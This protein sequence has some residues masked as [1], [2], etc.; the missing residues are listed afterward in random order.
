MK[1]FA[2]TTAVQTGLMEELYGLLT[3]TARDMERLYDSL[4][5]QQRAIVEWDY[6]V[7][8]GSVGEQNRLNRR[9]RA[10]EK[11]RRELIDQLSDKPGISIRELAVSL[12]E[13]W[14]SRLNRAA[15]NIRETVGK[16]GA[17]KKQNEFL[18][19]KAR[20]M[21]NSQLRLFME[22]ARINRNIYE[23][24]GKKSRRSNLHKVFDQ[25]A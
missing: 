23:E 21:V 15:L 6:A 13:P 10:R 4:R 3:E 1:A 12:G 5:A 25:Q 20:D 19:E 24:N 18:L 9:H 2:E 11:R 7:L 17:M 16:V 22:L 8:S 14:G